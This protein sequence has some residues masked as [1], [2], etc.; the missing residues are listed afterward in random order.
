ML[1]TYFN[2]W[3]VRPEFNQEFVSIFEGWLG[4][5]NLH[6]LG[7]VTESEWARF[8]SLLQLLHQNH[9]LYIADLVSNSCTKIEVIKPI[10]S[11]YKESINKSSDQFTKIILPELNAVFTEEWDYT[12]VLWVKNRAAVE[13]LSPLIKDV[14]LFHW[15]DE[16]LPEDRTVT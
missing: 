15:H 4:K 5:E 10:L 2:D 13:T 12:W 14:G 7:E 1:K 9:G 16:L 3:N 8:N 11:N 6:K